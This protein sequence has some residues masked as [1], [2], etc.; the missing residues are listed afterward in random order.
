MAAAI[1]S[2]IRYTSRAPCLHR[3]VS[4]RALFHLGDTGGHADDDARMHEG[5]A[6]VHLADEVMQH[7]LGHVEVRND[8]VLE[9]ADGLD[10]AGGTPHHRLGLVTDGEHRMIGLMYG[11]DG[12]LVHH[13]SF[14]ADID[15]G[16]GG[17]QIDGEV[18][19]EEPGK[20]AQQHS[21]ALPFCSVDGWTFTTGL[22][23]L[24]P[25]S[26]AKQ[27]DVTFRED[28]RRQRPNTAFHH[29]LDP[30]NAQSFQSVGYS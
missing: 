17:A 23:T 8:P 27:E 10:I 21:G 22:A 20:D 6:A 1:G 26:V 9:R 13:D 28:G 5:A 29:A 30:I 24:A 12:R 18:V 2:S 11:D 15:Q 3:R 19:G 4:N 7:L 14:P 25:R 16:I